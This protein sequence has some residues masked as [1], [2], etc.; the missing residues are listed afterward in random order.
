MSKK[1]QKILM[2][3]IMS[4]ILVTPV[5]SQSN[6]YAGGSLDTYM[7]DTI[8]GDYLFTLGDSQYSGELI[9]GANYNVTFDTALPEGI[10]I[11][12]A[13]LYLYW[14]WSH[15]GSEGVNPEMEVLLDG[16]PIVPEKEYS[17][18][19]GEGSY[20]YPSGTHAFNV[21]SYVLD[22]E[23]VINITNSGDGVFSINGAALLLIYE[24]AG[25]P[26]IEYWINEGADMIKFQEEDTPGNATTTAS[27]SGD[28]DTSTVRIADLITVVPSG[29]KGENTLYFNYDSWEG[30]YQGLPYSS[31][32][33]DTRDVTDS[34]QPNNN[35]VKIQD[36]GDYLIPSN[37]FLFIEFAVPQSATENPTGTPGFEVLSLVAAFL[38]VMSLIMYKRRK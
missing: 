6:G 28:I 3:L 29:D 1:L 33:V 35:V 5:A 18:R 19:K 34:L 16:N 7:H 10:N 23:S 17:D 31:L 21:A 20:D 38:A 32:A 30:V 25:S 8:N 22:D 4:M 9:S 13:R 11:S 27:F 36:N 15:N 12:V 26:K 24:Q 14:T 37:G 2:G